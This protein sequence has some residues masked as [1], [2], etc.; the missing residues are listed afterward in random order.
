MSYDNIRKLRKGTFEKAPK[1]EEIYRHENLGSN[2][3]QIVM[4]YDLAS[5]QII[6]AKI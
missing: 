2:L 3:S 6:S 5:R 1:I 4:K